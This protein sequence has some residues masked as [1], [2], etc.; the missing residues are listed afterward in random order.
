MRE[1]NKNQEE[2]SAALFKWAEEAAQVESFDML[3]DALANEEKVTF[4]WEQFKEF[5][6]KTALFVAHARTLS[7]TP[8]SQVI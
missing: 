1:L 6:R 2:L 7:I 5:E 3:K 4:L 8:M